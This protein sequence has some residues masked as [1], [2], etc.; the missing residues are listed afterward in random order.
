[1]DKGFYDLKYNNLVELWKMRYKEKMQIFETRGMLKYSALNLRRKSSLTFI[2]A[3][4]ER[5]G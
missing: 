3:I 1:M 5:K 4:M 2:M